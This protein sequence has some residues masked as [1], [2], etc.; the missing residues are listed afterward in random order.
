MSKHQTLQYPVDAALNPSTALPAL[1]KRTDVV[2]WATQLK[3]V[4]HTW[5]KDAESPFSTVQTE[6]GISDALMSLSKDLTQKV[7]GATALDSFHDKVPINKGKLELTALP[8]LM[9]LHNRRGLPAILFNYDR[10]QCEKTLH[11]VVSQLERAEVVWKGA[12][13]QW[14]KKLS[15]YNTWQKQDAAQKARAEKLQ[16]KPSKSRSQDDDASSNIDRMRQGSAEPS[17]WASFDPDAPLE[18]FSFADHTK[19]SNS[20]LDDFISTLND[21]KVDARLVAALRRGVA[22]HHAGLNRQ[23]RQ[24]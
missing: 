8:L 10:S 24:V 16:T 12:S 20:E 15:E 9:D 7:A 23:Y 18:M 6:L 2:Q 11:A 21:D 3:S 13:P 17:K 19:L 14:I 22:V 4:L 1:V 5:M